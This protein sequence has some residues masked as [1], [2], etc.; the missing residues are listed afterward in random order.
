MDT[1]PIIEDFDVFG[2]HSAGLLPRQH[3]PV[4]EFVL[5]SGEEGFGHRIVPADPGTTH[6]PDDSEAVQM[7]PEL[8][9]SI[10]TS[11]VGMEY[12]TLADLVSGGGHGEGVTDQVG[13]H[14]LGHRPA[15]HLFGAA[16]DDRGQVEPALP[17]LDV[18]DVLCRPWGYADVGCDCAG[19]RWFPG[20]RCRHS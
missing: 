11:A 18:G 20:L 2:N 16:I 13:A 6:R 14:V 1:D 15:D 3:Y 19:Q 10:L 9:R 4:D 7:L 5:Q 17:G 8:G 12:R